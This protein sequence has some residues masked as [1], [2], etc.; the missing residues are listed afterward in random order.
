M[1]LPFQ[2]ALKMKNRSQTLALFPLL[3]AWGG[4]GSGD[5][6]GWDILIHF[7]FCPGTSTII[8]KL[9][10]NF[11]ISSFIFWWITSAT[12]GQANGHGSSQP[13]DL[14]LL[15]N[16]IG[17]DQGYMMLGQLESLSRDY[18]ALGSPRNEN[19]ISWAALTISVKSL[20]KATYKLTH[21]H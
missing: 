2:S 6:L 14:L 11:V 1:L 17:L 7:L 16:D 12:N 13:S 4:G 5:N 21:C 8:L 3:I 10:A 15:F 20:S 19:S 18:V 9:V